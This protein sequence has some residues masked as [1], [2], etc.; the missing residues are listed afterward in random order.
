M[1]IALLSFKTLKGRRRRE[2]KSEGWRLLVWE[3]VTGKVIKTERE[4]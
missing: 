4:S 1:E 2:K 3:E